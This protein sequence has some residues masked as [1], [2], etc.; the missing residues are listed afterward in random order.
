MFSNDVR[1]EFNNH[2]AI[3]RANETN[4][5]LVVCVANDVVKI[6][7]TILPNSCTNIFKNILK[8]SD[9]KTDDLPGLLPLVYDMPV[10]LTSNICTKLGLTNGTNGIFK[11][12]IYEDTIDDNYTDL[13][14][15]L[16][17]PK[18][19]TIFLRKPL[20]AIIELPSCKINGVFTDLQPKLIP[21]PVTEGYFT[22]SSNKIFS[23]SLK[24]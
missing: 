24:N 1:Q 13:N 19:T 20:C 4:H 21:I 9:D 10:V 18:N 5:K 15:D 6:G 17:F 2:I 14:D 3:S 22:I 11:S 23:R 16:I 12:L 8:L 7:K